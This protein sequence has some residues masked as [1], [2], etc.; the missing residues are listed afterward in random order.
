MHLQIKTLK[1]SFSNCGKTGGSS[2]ILI[3]SLFYAN[4]NSI[5][6]EMYW[7]HSVFISKKEF[8]SDKIY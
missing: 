4:K 3:K 2:F 1:N 6:Q 7:F 8:Y 5:R